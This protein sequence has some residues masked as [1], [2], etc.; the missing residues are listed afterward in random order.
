LITS[1]SATYGRST[2]IYSR[3]STSTSPNQPPPNPEPVPPPARR[4]ARF[5]W[6][7]GLFLYTQP[8]GKSQLSSDTVNL[9]SHR[10]HSS[11]AGH[12]FPQRQ[13]FSSSITNWHPVSRLEEPSGP[14]QLHA[15][16]EASENP[17]T[18]VVPPDTTPKMREGNRVVPI[19][20]KSPTRFLRVLQTSGKPSTTHSC[21]LLN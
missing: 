18:K 1:A 15:V 3:S 20:V 12:H 14:N 21:S 10:T 19:P 2:C 5:H 6:T 13:T 16:P 8:S 17:A 4:R 7:K 11:S 9:A